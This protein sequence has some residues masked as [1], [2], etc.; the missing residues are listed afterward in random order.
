MAHAL[1]NAYLGL[2]FSFGADDST[3]KHEDGKKIGGLRARLLRRAIFTSHAMVVGLDLEAF[4]TVMSVWN[5]F[6]P[7]K[8][9]EIEKATKAVVDKW[10]NDPAC[11]T[12]HHDPEGEV[13]RCFNW[14]DATVGHH[15]DLLKCELNPERFKEMG[16]EVE[17]IYGL[18][19]DD[20]G[21][22][23][24]SDE[25]M[26]D[27]DWETMAANDRVQP[28][29]LKYVRTLFLNILQEQYWNQIHH[30]ML[31]DEDSIAQTMLDTLDV[32]R[33]KVEFLTN[34]AYDCPWTNADT[35]ERLLPFADWAVFEE[36]RQRRGTWAEPLT[37]CTKKTGEFCHKTCKAHVPAVHR[38]EAFAE[39]A[40]AYIH[41]HKEAQLLLA[42]FVGVGEG[43]DDPEEKLVILESKLAV[44]EAVK[45][46]ATVFNTEPGDA[47]NARDV[48]VMLVA[49]KLAKIAI[50]RKINELHGMQEKG[51]L[52]PNEQHAVQHHLQEDR[53]AVDDLARSVYCKWEHEVAGLGSAFDNAAKDTAYLAKRDE[54]MAALDVRICACLRGEGAAAGGGEG[55]GGEGREGVGETKSPGVD[56]ASI[57]PQGEGMEG[58][59]LTTVGAKAGEESSM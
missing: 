58:V 31:V 53:D 44:Q 41:G 7:T 43:I 11:T 23:K 2:K 33:D 6:K 22:V 4:L 19:E 46:F 25:K 24:E 39:M 28:G 37:A 10:K 34:E 3:L 13:H 32:A 17:L 14:L 21:A 12:H 8:K 20:T 30:K 29:K 1:P 26:T 54:E 56:S 50:S 45:W 47:D 9:H 18:H 48:V 36:A 42:K 27:T 55:D 35:T 59:E 38:E 5:K 40:R 15:T 51:L 52:S 57:S 16:K 49:K